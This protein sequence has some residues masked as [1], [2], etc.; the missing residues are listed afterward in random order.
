MGTTGATATHTGSVPGS[1]LDA[2]VRIEA[3]RWGART[4]ISARSVLVTVL[5]DV[6]APTGGSVWLAD[7]FPLV[8]PFGFNHRLVRTSMYRLAAEH[9]VDNERIG[10]RSRYALTGFGRDE[11]AA[12][13]ARIYHH[14][15]AVWDGS[16]TVVIPAADGDLRRHLGWR[17][18]GEL[19][20]GI[21]ARPGSARDDLAPLFTR[22]GLP[23]PPP[24]AV[25]RFDDVNGL[26][27]ADGYRDT[28]GLAD[29]ETAYR[30]FL[31]RHR[32][33]DPEALATLD[34]EAAFLVRTMVVHDFR[35]ARL[36]DPDLPP[37]LLPA[38]WVGERARR[39]AATVYRAVAAASWR[40]I[41]S[42]TD[43]HPDPDHPHLAGRFAAG[44]R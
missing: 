41:G 36:R 27:A 31:D 21:M 23:A 39:Q 5:G 26:I 29:T 8:E 13:D 1:E 30:E 22:L 33:S 24:V 37:E 25:A 7:L 19:A 28:S 14:R 10:R 6:I 4:T 15:P 43:L 18:F 20:E 32:W 17:G 40:W 38:G 2:E 3:R 11:F 9:W 12:A 34:P 35:R 16:W 42:V 44:G